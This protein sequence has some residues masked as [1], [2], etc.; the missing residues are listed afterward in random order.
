[1]TRYRNLTGIALL[2]CSLLTNA[3]Q[4]L[5]YGHDDPDEIDV[6]TSVLLYRCSPDAFSLWLAP[7]NATRQDGDRVLP[8]DTAMQPI[9][10]SRG[11]RY[12]V[13]SEHYR[14]DASWGYCAGAQ[15][16]EVRLL[17]DEQLLHDDYLANYCSLNGATEFH[18]DTQD[19]F[20]TVQRLDD[21]TPVN[22]CEEAPAKKP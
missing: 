3:G 7:E 6:K 2:A 11:H 14:G 15:A 22:R 18:F 10:E 5:P 20:C 17:R 12:S 4:S 8:F 13:S 19:R 1:M 16:I 9:C 21:G